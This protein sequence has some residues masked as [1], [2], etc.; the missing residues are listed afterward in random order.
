MSDHRPK[1][2][3]EGASPLTSQIRLWNEHLESQLAPAHFTLLMNKALV[4][5]YSSAHE[6]SHTLQPPSSRSK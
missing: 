6:P 4:A 2:M 3:T 1:C 5:S